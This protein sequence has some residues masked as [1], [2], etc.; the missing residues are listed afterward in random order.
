M[1]CPLGAAP[2]GMETPTFFG[3]DVACLIAERL[4]DAGTLTR[5]AG[6]CKLTREAVASSAAG[7]VLQRRL[8]ASDAVIMAA[9][10]GR[11][12]VV[13]NV[14][15]RLQERLPGLWLGQA[16]LDAA[17][18]GYGAS[19]VLWAADTRPWLVAI[20]AI[21]LVVAGARGNCAVSVATGL[22]ALGSDNA[23]L[24]VAKVVIR[25]GESFVEGSCMMLKAVI[26]GALQSDSHHAIRL[27][28]LSI[29]ITSHAPEMVQ[30]IVSSSRLVDS[31]L[32]AARA[33]AHDQVQRLHH[34]DRMQR[35]EYAAAHHDDLYLPASTAE[36]RTLSD[37]MQ[38]A[39]R[40]VQV[41]SQSS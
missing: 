38:R 23:R 37:A 3:L 9:R 32:N 10:T 20:I 11:H 34:T 31:E 30:Q 40:V 39:D 14:A 13:R 5:F 24:A 26:E 16:V 2:V 18:L 36:D 29:A 27:E 17:R 12:D 21:D 25:G 19:V 4:P 8:P 6:M 28:L 35:L 15:N 7:W 22:A 1:S 41:L 33:A